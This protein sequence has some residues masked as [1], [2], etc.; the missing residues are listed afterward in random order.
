M[1][2]ALIPVTLRKGHPALAHLV[3]L[4]VHQGCDKEGKYLF[5]VPEKETQLRMGKT[6]L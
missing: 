5:M 4:S 3:Q 6:F 1:N 2:E